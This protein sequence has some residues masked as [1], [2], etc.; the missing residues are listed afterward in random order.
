MHLDPLLYLSESDV[1]AMCSAIDPLTIVEETF[2][3]TL[4]GTANIAAETALRWTAPDG[5]AARSLV[6]PARSADS[7]GCKIINACIGN[8]DR[9]LPRAHG[10]VL[11]YDS[12]TAAPVCIMDGGAIS[13][14]RTTAVST[15]AVRA[16]RDP[17]TVRTIAFL[18]CG[19]Q[20][21][22][23]LETLARLCPN[24]E[25]ATVFDIQPQRASRFAVNKRNAIS[26]R[27]RATA[28]AAVRHADLVVAAT[29]TTTPYIELDWLQPGST[30]LNVSLDDATEETL[31]Q[32][33]HLI[34]DDWGLVKSDGHRLL[35]RLAQ[36]GT[37]V[38][39]REST[40]TAIRQVDASIAT[41]LSSNY[42]RTVQPQDRVVINPFG[43]GVHDVALAAEI[44]GIATRAAKGIQ[45]PR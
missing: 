2:R 25:H 36:A 13:A 5:T 44:Y 21:T 27:V 42:A 18:G 38:G 40:A 43:M 45:L 28:E 8:I 35:G 3:R 19:R 31:L 33:E 37:V 30:L 24:I 32:C 17:T 6:L 34:V 22:A 7:Y 15:V 14:L 4:Q 20:A 9:G 1:T 16:L 39:P 10:L 23:H 12:V 41:V 11:L 29:T 26:V